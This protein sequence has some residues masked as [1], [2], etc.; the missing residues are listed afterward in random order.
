M[1]AK[2]AKVNKTKFK[3]EIEITIERNYDSLIE[4]ISNYKEI[5]GQ[6][7]KLISLLREHNKYQDFCIK[8]GNESLIRET[9]RQKL[10]N[11]FL[12]S[13]MKTTIN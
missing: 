2:K 1:N 3:S 9:E 5:K 7:G 11:L 13:R 6:N 12:R 8:C 4:L 10:Q